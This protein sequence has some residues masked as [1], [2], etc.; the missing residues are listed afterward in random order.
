MDKL[1]LKAFE[2][3]NETPPIWIMR[4]AGRYLP[5]YR[6]VRSNF[7]TFMDFCLTPEAAAEV[8]IQ[9]ISRFNFDAAIIFSDILIIPKA[10]GIEVNF[11]ENEGPILDRIKSEK[12]LSKLTKPNEEIFSLVAKA[13]S[14]VRKELDNKFPSTA[15]IGFVGSPFTVASY[16][17]EGRG[18]RKS[19]FT[20]M[21]EIMVGNMP[22]LS[23]IIKYII[24]ASKIYI[25]YQIEA[26]AE[27]IKLFDSWAEI[28]PECYFDELIFNPNEEIIKFIKLNY[29]HIKVICFPRNIGIKAVKF[30]KNSSMDC[31]ALDQHNSLDLLSSINESKTLQGNLDNNLLAYSD[32]TEIENQVK[33]I[34]DTMRSKKFIFNLGHGILP[35]TPIENVQY[36]IDTVRSYGK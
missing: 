8:T 3:A 26:G 21:K 13:I 6:K 23:Q 28:V 1:F 27:V 12:D 34:M 32:K 35:S 11:K 10:L 19:D 29:P 15:L 20:I 5:E 36:L 30:M 24:G 16:M 31:V 25:K 2:Q 22:L 4:Q 9:P 33:N 14:L 7:K 17:L 18:G